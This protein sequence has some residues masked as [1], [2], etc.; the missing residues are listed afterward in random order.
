M[1]ANRRGLHAGLVLFTALGTVAGG[2]GRTTAQER[3]P[4]PAYTGERVY[5]NDVPGAYAT[6]N[7][8][9][10]ELER[11][12]PQTYFVVVIR[13]AGGRAEAATK[14]VDELYDT[15]RSQ[16][17]SRGLK[18]DPERSV[19]TLVAIS[20]RRVAVHAGSVLQ[21]RLGLSKEV[22]NALIDRAFVPLARGEK[23]PDAIASLLAAINNELAQRDAATALVKTGTSLF[24]AAAPGT[25][26]ASSG[27]T[28]APGLLRDANPQPTQESPQTKS[29]RAA[30]QAPAA[31]STGETRRSDLQT[32]VIL[33][34]VASLLAVGLIGGLLIWLAR[35]RTRNTVEGKIKEYRKKAVDVMDRL[36]AL[37]ARLKLLPTEDTD[38]KE[39]MA[40]ETLALYE[41]TQA[42]L[43]G[44]WDRWLE[45]MDILDKAQALAQKDSAL[46]T[47]KLREAEK[48]VSDSRLFEQ[49]DEEARACAESMDQLNSAHENAR[50]A[51][52]GVVASQK[53][54]HVRI[55]KLE[56]EGLPTVPYKP[57]VDEIAAQADHA[58]E[59]LTPD[60]IGAR[61]TLDS[62]QERAKT[63]HE[64]IEQILARYVDGRKI[65]AAL[66]A[67]GESVA[68]HRKGGLRLD[69]EG[70]DPD[71]PIAQT[72]QALEAL[73]RAVH[74]GNPTAALEHL[75]AGHSLMEQAQR[76]L[77]EVLQAKKQ[78][79]TDLPE[80][81]RH[82]RRLREALSQYEAFEAELKRDFA[83]ETW[84]GVA[85]NLAHA[86]A[87]LE[88]FDKKT[89]EVAVDASSTTQKYL[90]GARLL[91]QVSQEQQA[92]FQLMSA[93][94]DQLAGLKALR[95]ECQTAVRSLEDR[96]HAVE[97]Y[98]R[99]NDQVIGGLARGTVASAQ[100]SQQ[101]L[102]AVLSE[103][104]PDWPRVRQLL[105]RTLEE[106]AVAG[107]QAEADV[108]TYQQLSSEFDRVRQDA[109][110]VGAFLAGHEEDRL[111]ANQHYQNAQNS[112]NQV[113][114]ESAR[115]GG[116]WSRW[117]EMVRGAAT[118]LARS[119]QLAQEDI[120]LAQQAE[121]ELQEAERTISQA[122]AYFSSGVTLDTM[123]AEGQLAEA[124][125]LY[126]SQNYEEAIRMAASAIQQARQAH[127][128]AA[129][130]A[131]RRR[132]T[133]ESN[134]RRVSAPP[135]GGPLLSM[136]GAAVS[137]EGAP[138]GQP[139]SVAASTSE[140]ESGSG[141]AA[142][143][144]SSETAE[145][146]W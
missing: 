28:A 17:Q 135:L 91:S 90:R 76:T 86:S 139:E 64:R 88:T 123:G 14:Y 83:P 62:A 75:Q 27:P 57:E 4:I 144:W 43:T 131:F 2:A 108:Q 118:D 47:E 61:Q 115:P 104:R 126:R 23:Y 53:E 70:G 46:G 15:W 11:S 92:V 72:F 80:R 51:A 67:L 37:K 133:I 22:R 39:P 50:T 60:P 1:I 78:C 106:F 73:R 98:F 41:K 44:V 10:K 101:E 113:Q 45:V 93:V 119:E 5:L 16:A 36:D 134:R 8:A 21:G 77:D 132:M 142:G 129:Q 19:I 95:E 30:T 121:S 111:A 65:S 117:L 143:S 32:Q 85:G 58:E 140:P 127:A 7:K 56:K 26:A 145:R 128:V 74:D 13:S 12:S 68:S 124:D 42:H 109:G 110:R 130:E 102:A 35:R 94:G 89:V 103:S 31:G 125:R 20:D 63:L 40:G 138:S 82:T 114:A 6:V 52:D 55:E 38:F 79:E 81:V 87:L 25:L 136:G 29:G 137:S 112:L 116:E 96:A 48:L 18:L 69:E 34:L 120:R 122:R 84:Q 33:A 3:T 146:G 49:I 141:T 54:I 24:P 105:A 66:A 71:H 107:N 99:Q 59:I 100:T 9:I 97:R